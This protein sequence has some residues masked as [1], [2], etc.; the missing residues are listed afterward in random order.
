MREEE[1]GVIATVK[2]K[3]PSNST[4]GVTLFFTYHGRYTVNIRS[5]NCMFS[6]EIIIG[7]HKFKI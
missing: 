4:R 7:N 2:A 6:V 5:L 1:F 3:S